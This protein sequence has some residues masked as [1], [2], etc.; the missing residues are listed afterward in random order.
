MFLTSRK[1]LSQMFSKLLFFIPRFPE[2]PLTGYHWGIFWPNKARHQ[3][4]GQIHLSRR[5]SASFSP[6]WGQCPQFVPVWSEL[7]LMSLFMYLPLYPTSCLWSCKTF[8]SA[9]LVT[10]TSAQ[11]HGHHKH[12]NL[13]TDFIYH[14][15]FSCAAVGC[16]CTG[17]GQTQRAV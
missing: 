14:D 9:S 11:G 16:L 3:R 4:D 5:H 2:N 13:E 6:R 12:V 1:P 8:V 17:K 7:L 15:N 10:P